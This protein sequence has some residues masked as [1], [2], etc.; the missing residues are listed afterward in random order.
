MPIINELYA[1]VVEEAP[2]EEGIMGAL[3]PNNQWMPFIGADMKRVEDL[4]PMAAQISEHAK[5][6]YKI[7]H[8]KLDGE[9]EK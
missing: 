8:F 2:G 9:F 6:P 7:L 3:M 1:F 4:K 5:L